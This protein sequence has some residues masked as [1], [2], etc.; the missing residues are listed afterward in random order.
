MKELSKEE[1]KQF[2][3]EHCLNCGSLMCT[4]V[5]E[6]LAGCPEFKKFRDEHQGKVE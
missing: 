4:S 2:R 1:M 3:Q 5:G 6:W